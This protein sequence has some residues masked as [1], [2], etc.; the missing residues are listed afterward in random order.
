MTRNRRE[1]IDDLEQTM[2]AGQYYDVPNDLASAL[3]QANYA[4]PAGKESKNVDN[5]SD[6]A[7]GKTDHA[8][9]SKR[10]SK[11]GRKRRRQSD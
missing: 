7:K 9:S 11:G 3:I 2:F 5:I 10:V 6:A 8:S 1:L 4:E